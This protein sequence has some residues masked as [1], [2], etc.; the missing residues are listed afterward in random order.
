[1]STK[2]EIHIYGRRDE[3]PVKLFHYHDGYPAG[4]GCFL[5]EAVYPKFLYS[6]ADTSEDIAQ[7]LVYHTAD[8][9][10][11]YTDGIHPDIEFLY[12]INVPAKTIRC[13][14]GCYKVWNKRGNRLKKPYFMKYIEC[15]LKAKFLPLNK[16]V[17]YR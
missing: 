15:D 12:E 1:M 2:S 14:K 16:R 6:N 4:V 7:F 11:E 5:M 9:E 10:F 17:K 3:L 8:D 13:F